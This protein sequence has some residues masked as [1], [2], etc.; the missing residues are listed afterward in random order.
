MQYIIEMN[1][2]FYYRKWIINWLNFKKLNV[3]VHV[4]QLNLSSRFEYDLLPVRVG[5]HAWH[6]HEAHWNDSVWYKE[7]EGKLAR[8]NH[9]G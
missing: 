4:S 2:Y 9:T 7:S 3:S 5:Q 6:D 8:V 1:K